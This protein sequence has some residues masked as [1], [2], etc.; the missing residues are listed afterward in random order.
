M[1]CPYVSAE[2][3]TV[4]GGMPSLDVGLLVLRPQESHRQRGNRGR[5]STEDVMTETAVSGNDYLPSQL[6]IWSNGPDLHPNC[7]VNNSLHEVIL[8]LQDPNKP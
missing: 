1:S 6:E 8:W 3:R 2:H 5:S 4:L 7:S